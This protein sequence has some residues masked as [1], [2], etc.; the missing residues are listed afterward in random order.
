MPIAHELVEEDEAED[1]AKDL[2]AYMR[3]HGLIDD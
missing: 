2:A 3:S 1:F